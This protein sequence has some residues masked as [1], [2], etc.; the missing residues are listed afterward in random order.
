MK[1][2]AAI[3][4]ALGCGLAVS[5]GRESPQEPGGESRLQVYVYWRDTGLPEKRLEVLELGLERWTDQRGIAEF[6]IPA[7]RYTLRAHEINRPGPPPA[8]IDMNVRTSPGET[9]R[10]EV[11]DCL[12]C[13]APN[14]LRFR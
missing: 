2:T 9:T 14:G 1:P 8:Y 4:L 7:G 6:V 11:G 3:A 10:I 5:C 13:V 12:P